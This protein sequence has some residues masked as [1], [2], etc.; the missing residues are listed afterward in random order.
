MSIRSAGA[1]KI[2][3]WSAILYGES[4]HW[5]SIC[6]KFVMPIDQWKDS[7]HPCNVLGYEAVSGKEEGGGGGV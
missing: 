4:V 6:F 7:S 2:L 3:V 5:L 1:E